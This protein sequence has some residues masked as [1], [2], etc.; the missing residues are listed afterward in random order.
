MDIKEIIFKAYKDKAIITKTFK[1]E[2][3]KN[4]KLSD[5][6]VRNLYIRI[7]NYQIKKYGARLE[8]E[9]IFVYTNDE[10]ARRRQNDRDR[11]Y[12]RKKRFMSGGGKK[13][14]E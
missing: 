5:E 7:N 8:K 4:Y 2:I 14:G 13:N 1:N 10:L 12:K 11:K 3:A 9:K 6:D